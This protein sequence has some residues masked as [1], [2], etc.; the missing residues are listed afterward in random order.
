MQQPTEISSAEIGVCVEKGDWIF[1]ARG[2][3]VEISEDGNNYIRIAA[4]NYPAMKKE[5]R[6]GVFNHKLTFEPVKA[7]YVKVI[8]NSERQIPEWHG[9]KGNLGFL[10]VDEI[11]LN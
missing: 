8:A 10:F 6:N 7:R 5:A 9:G 3:A 2:F 4:E 1:D 11:V